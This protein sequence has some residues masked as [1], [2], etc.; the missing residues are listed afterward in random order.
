MCL[1]VSLRALSRGAGVSLEFS[2]ISVTLRW[3]YSDDHCRNRVCF[4]MLSV[5]NCQLS[6]L[7]VLCKN[8][9]L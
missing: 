5:Q 6:D 8:D 9:Y 4:V 1:V 7:C 2:R 3:F